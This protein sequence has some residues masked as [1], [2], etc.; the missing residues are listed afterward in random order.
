MSQ[1]IYISSAD[2][3]SGNSND[4]LLFLDDE[5]LR[6][7]HKDLAVSEAI[8]P[9]SYYAINDNNNTFECGPTGADTI[10]IT[11]GNYTSSEFATHLA[12]QL[13]VVLVPTYS[14]SFSTNTGKFTYSTGDAS[15]F[16]L[17]ADTKNYKYLGFAKNSSNSSASGSLVSTNVINISGTEYVDILSNLQVASENSSN[18][19]RD[20]LARIYPNSSAFSSI[21]FNAT[22]DN[23]VHFAGQHINR[24]HIR[25]VDE[26]GDALDLNGLDWNFTLKT[27]PRAVVN[28]ANQA[29]QPTHEQPTRGF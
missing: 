2:R 8:I 22:T 19:N 25:L 13:N 14:V 10:T 15:E 3:N 27:V 20:V 28:H 24:M 5:L 1:H 11:N 26:H 17:V 9:H 16:V 21:F 12:T 6:D 7:Q 18:L 29:P 23:A 4:F